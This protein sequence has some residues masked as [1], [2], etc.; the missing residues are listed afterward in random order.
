MISAMRKTGITTAMAILAPV[1]RPVL[2]VDLVTAVEEDEGV[3][4]ALEAAV[5][6]VPV[7][8]ETEEETVEDDDAEAVLDETALELVVVV[9]AVKLILK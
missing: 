4:V 3:E 6:A 5:E 7:E 8:E 2:D 9:S 1:L